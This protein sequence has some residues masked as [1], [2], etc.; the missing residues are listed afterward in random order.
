MG[1]HGCERPHPQP[2]LAEWRFRRV[3][4]F[5]PVLIYMQNQLLHS[6][7]GVGRILSEA[8]SCLDKLDSPWQL[9]MGWSRWVEGGK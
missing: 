9:S 5:A 3:V 6:V 7:Q 2:C 8:M 4:T 1:Q